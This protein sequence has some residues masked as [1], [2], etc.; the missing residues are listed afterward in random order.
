MANREFYCGLDA[1]LSI[2]SGRWKFLVLWE[3]DARGPTRYGELRRA[4][5]GVSEK[6]LISALRDLREAGVIERRDHKEIPPRV[7]YALTGLG[8]DL[9]AALQPLAVWGCTNMPTRRD[10]RAAER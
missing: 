8:R 6:M 5:E 7:E 3:L 9:A 10:H 2:V 4:L 1:A